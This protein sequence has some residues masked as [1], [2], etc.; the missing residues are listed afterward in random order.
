[1]TICV[2]FDA[3]GRKLIVIIAP[4]LFQFASIDAN[5]SLKGT[6][7]VKIDANGN[8][9]FKDT[10]STICANVTLLD[11]ETIYIV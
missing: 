1:M 3:N 4:R 2:N 9:F 8:V 11:I 7:C 10:I 6:V 5:G